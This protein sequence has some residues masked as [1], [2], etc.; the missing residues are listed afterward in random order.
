MELK[1][2]REDGGAWRDQK[3]VESDGREVGEVET[4]DLKRWYVN[5]QS[6]SHNHVIKM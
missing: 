5:K 4:G 6:K 2:E 3:K 1:R